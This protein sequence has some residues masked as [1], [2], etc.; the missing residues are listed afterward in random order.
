[1][2]AH[3]PRRVMLAMLLVAAP[4]FASFDMTGI[5]EIAC[6]FTSLPPPPFSPTS[7]VWEVTQTGSSLQVHPVSG[8]PTGPFEGIDSATGSFSIVGLF[9]SCSTPS[10]LSGILTQGGAAF[11]GTAH[12]GI[13]SPTPPSGC[14]DFQE[15]CIGQRVA[16]RCGD[17]VVSP[18]NGEA[19]DDG[20][21]V[22]GDGCSATCT[23]E[24]CGN[25][26]L[27][28]G[29]ACDEGW[30]QN[31]HGLVGC[32]TSGCALIDMDGDG[33]CDRHDNCFDVPD[34][35]GSDRDQ[36]GAGDVCDLTPDFAV[37]E[38]LDARFLR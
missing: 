22:S 5:W 37:I 36:D 4:A 30:Q 34:P 2:R 6:S 23:I 29:E 16:P 13:Y 3:R 8:Y 18:S 17:G 1:M 11:T 28:P 26:Q 21:Q 24:D 33:I 25:G 27:D 9:G 15:T 12:L 35:T 10:S 32:C 14:V 38:R 20:N 7:P 19:C 31:G